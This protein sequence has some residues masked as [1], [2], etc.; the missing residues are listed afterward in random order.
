MKP[1]SP[2]AVKSVWEYI[3]AAPD[4]ASPRALWWVERINNGW[5]P[6]RRV[7]S[8]GYEEASKFYG[9]YIWEYVNIIRTALEMDPSR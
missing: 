6:N 1:P 5:R 9:V 8:F 3:E 4:T 7:K 2:E